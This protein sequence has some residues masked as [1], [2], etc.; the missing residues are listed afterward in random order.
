M[1]LGDWEFSELR[2]AYVSKAGIIGYRGKLSRRDV[3]SRKLACA[4]WLG[5]PWYHHMSASQIRRQVGRNIW[6][7]YFKFCV[8]RNPFEKVVSG[9]HFFE[10]LERRG[11]RPLGVPAAPNMKER[12]SEWVKTQVAKKRALFDRDRYMIRGEVCVDYFIRYE[13]LS[14]GVQKVCE[15]INVPVDHKLPQL[16]TGFRPQGRSLDEYY[17]EPTKELVCNTYDF[18][19]EYFGYEFPTSNREP[20]EGE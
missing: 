2:E 15:M 16:K 6:D 9:F 17:D 13:N 3:I 5:R 1:E 8:V 4:S 18:E 19:M 7:N 10:A 20:K 11:I 14:A 12:F